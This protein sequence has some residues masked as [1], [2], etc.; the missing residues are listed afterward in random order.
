MD[1]CGGVEI[2]LHAFYT[3]VLDASCQ[4]NAPAALLPSKD[5]AAH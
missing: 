5:L 4:L 1:V 2:W 3:S